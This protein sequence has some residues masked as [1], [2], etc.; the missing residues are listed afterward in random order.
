MKISPTFIGIGAQK[1]ATT[2]L[3]DLLQL[4]PAVG[5]SSVK[6]IHFF[7][8]YFGYGYQWYKS[9]FNDCSTNVTS[10]G[11]F[12]TSYFANLTAPKLIKSAYPDIKLILMLRNPI[13]R[14]ISNH[15]HEIKIGHL[16][17]PDFSYEAG[18]AN[19]PTYIEQ[20][21]Y[22]QHLERWYDFFDSQQIHIVIF[23]DIKTKPEAVEHGL[24]QFLKIELLKNSHLLGNSNSSYVNRFENVEKIR[25][26][27]LNLL[28]K[29]HLESSYQ[30]VVETLGLQAA[31]RKVNRATFDNII[32]PMKQETRAYLQ[33]IFKPEIVRLEELTDIKLG[34][35]KQ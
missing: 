27:V 25:R 29:F 19:N 14:L 17:G 24:Y 21:L 28:K 7:S 10:V 18:I 20:G 11:E 23:D 3:Y 30:A 34:R 15:K 16:T 2:W 26:N 35:W 33:E 13:E 5:L 4:H 6:E 22:A 32:P 9:H 12:S 1:C 31:Y 8:Q